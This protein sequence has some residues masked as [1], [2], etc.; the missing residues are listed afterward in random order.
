GPGGR[1]RARRDGPPAGPG[2]AH[3]P[4]AIHRPGHDRVAGDLL[5]GGGAD[6]AVRQPV[7]EQVAGAAVTFNVWTFLFEVLNFLVL[8]FVLHRL[9]YRPLREAV[10][11]RKAEND[12]ARVE[13][14]AARKE[15]DAARE[16]L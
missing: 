10:D 3:Q 16:Q 13:A 4:D 2:G 12:K 8:A 7:H 6:P 15:A 9:L 5:P 1:F 11:K 14:E